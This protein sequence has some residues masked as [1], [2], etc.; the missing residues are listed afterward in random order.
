MPDRFRVLLFIACIASSSSVYGANKK[1]P[2]EESDE[3]T[4]LKSSYACSKKCMEVYGKYYNDVF[5]I[6][7]IG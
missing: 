3:I 5:G 4:S 6:K 1:V 2:F 7:T